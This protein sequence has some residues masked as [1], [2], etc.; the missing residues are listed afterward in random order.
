MSYFKIKIGDSERIYFATKAQKLQSQN[1]GIGELVIIY[2]FLLNII[3][4][5]SAPENNV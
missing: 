4:R 5:C 1:F 2:Y 3:L